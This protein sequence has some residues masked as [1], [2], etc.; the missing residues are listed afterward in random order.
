MSAHWTAND[1]AASDAIVWHRRWRI[2]VDELRALY[3]ANCRVRAWLQFGRVP[4]VAEG[5]IADLRFEHPI[6]QNFTPMAVETGPR[7]CPAHVTDW[8]L[9]RRDVLTASSDSR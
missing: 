8:Q 4:H 7:G 2:D 1:G 6:G 9:P 3:A 5:T